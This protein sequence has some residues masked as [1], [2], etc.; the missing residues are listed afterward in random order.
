MCTSF[1]TVVSV[2]CARPPP[3]RLDK[4]KAD[5]LA[6]AFV[7]V[8][9]LWFVTQCIGRTVSGL[10]I[11]EIEPMN[12]TWPVEIYRHS[13]RPKDGVSSTT[14]A[15]IG[16]GNWVLAVLQTWLTGDLGLLV[17][18]HEFHDEFKK[19][20][21]TSIH[22]PANYLYTRDDNT[23]EWDLDAEW[24]VWTW[25]AYSIAPAIFGALHSI[26]WYSSFPSSTERLLWRASCI[27][28]AVHALLFIVMNGTGI[29][30][31]DSS[32]GI[33]GWAARALY[34]TLLAVYMF[35]SNPINLFARFVFVILPL[36]QFRDLPPL[37]HQTVSWSDFLPHV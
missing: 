14:K 6:K 17:D 4:S 26:A 35:I 10:P 9:C 22:Y 23:T 34:L 12:V 36:L 16:V 2:D 20:K 11:I 28:P 7:V 37:S 30:K 25:V 21:K 5:G 18:P 27:I 31:H 3:H 8:Q 33:A 13:D 15:S 29:G 1:S 19:I 24:G 32:S